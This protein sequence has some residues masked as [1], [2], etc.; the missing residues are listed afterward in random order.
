MLMNRD[1][2][3][4]PLAFH[5][6]FGSKTHARDRSGVPRRGR[7]RAGAAAERSA[8]GGD[9]H[10]L[11]RQAPGAGAILARRP[12]HACLGRAQ[13]PH[14]GRRVHGVR[15]RRGRDLRRAAA[16]GA[17][18]RPD[19]DRHG[20]ARAAPRLH[21]DHPAR[22]RARRARDPAHRA[23]A[24]APG[25]RLRGRRGRA[26]RRGSPRG[27][28]W[29]GRHVPA[30][31]LHLRLPLR[32]QRHH[33]DRPGGGHRLLV[34]HR[35]SPPGGDPASWRGGRAG[36]DHGDGRLG[37][38]LLRPHRGRRAPGALLASDREPRLHRPVR[39]ARGLLR[40]ALR[41]HVPARP[42]GGA[43]PPPG[44]VA[45]AA[46]AARRQWGPRLLGA[47]DHRGDEP[48]LESA[49][50][51]GGGVAPARLAVRANPPGRQ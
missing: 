23:G 7:A 18:G 42:A 33:D 43:G 16:A 30:Q 45:G 29:D 25:L 5:L 34:V 13:G 51:G 10:R 35:E 3:Q 47:S 1:L 46:S 20:G 11:E 37:D 41:P 49:A 4:R 21:G 19:G 14:G 28:R 17:L 22:R 32:R 36:A 50:P 9:P 48:P 15:R 2:P 31:P 40:R 6:V 12:P 38:P 24:V 44:R 8:R 27:C 26:V 39:H